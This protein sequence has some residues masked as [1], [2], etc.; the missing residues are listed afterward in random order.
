MPFGAS[1]P[2]WDHLTLVLGLQEHLLPV[3][4]NPNAPI[5]PNSALKKL[6]QIPSLYNASGEV[7][8]FAKWTD[9][10]STIK[11]IEKWKQNPDYGICIQ[12]REIRAFDCDI[13]DEALA[14]KVFHFFTGELTTS[15]PT[16]GR[17]NASKFLKPFRI[18]GRY[19]KRILKLKGGNP[20]D[21]IELLADG[22]Q[23]IS[24]GMHPSGS[25]YEWANGLPTEIPELTPEDFETFWALLETTFG[26]EPSTI[27]S[28]ALRNAPGG[29]INDPNLQFLKKANII[30]GYSPEGAAYVQC[31]FKSS[32]TKEGDKTETIYFPAGLRDYKQGHFNCFHASCSDKTD[33][34]FLNVLGYTNS[35][36]DILPVEEDAPQPSA[37]RFTFTD[38]ASF[39]SR[40]P[41]DYIIKKV[42]P[43]ADLIVLFGESGAGKSFVALDMAFAIGRGVDWNGHKTRQGRVAYVVAE[44]AGGFQ[45]RAQ[46]YARHYNI[47]LTHIPFSVLA[48]QPNLL[49]IK[50][51]A[52]LSLAIKDLGDVSVVF[53]DTFAQTTPGAN[54]NSAEDI[55][56]ALQ[57]CRKISQTTGAT[58]VL[59]HHAGKDLTKGARGWSGLRAAADAEIEISR[60]EKSRSMKISKQKDGEDGAEWGLV[61]REVALGFD[62]DEAMISSCIV[63]YTQKQR[64]MG[65]EKKLGPLEKLILETFESI[66]KQYIAVELLSSDVKTLLPKPD[67]RDTRAQRITRALEALSARGLLVIKDDRVSAPL[68]AE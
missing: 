3:V 47:N 15:L 31:P 41:Q 59:I 60:S 34:D 13:T 48:D 16:R 64:P 54:E 43:K 4:S 33:D 1:P 6:G 8:G 51:T 56:K 30:L 27:E 67:G 14:E 10:H 45:K 21:K 2:D 55:G 11:E 44:G 49:D 5:S 12:T 9:H 57:H 65:E 7:S 40:L 28:H 35:L 24:V 63:E 20:S 66:G 25:R 46:A 62:E 18:K 17:N 58:V 32:H 52:A 53:I 22:Q 68:L 37:Q 38:I 29:E 61:L 36:F 19:P 50:D 23:F 42:M 39:S 26:A